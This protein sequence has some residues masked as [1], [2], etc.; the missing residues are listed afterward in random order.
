MGQYI[1]VFRYMRLILFYTINFMLLH[2]EA[3]VN[4]F[5][6]A[7][8]TKS[9]INIPY[10]F[11]LFTLS[12]SELVRTVR[13]Q[14]RHSQRPNIETIG[15]PGGMMMTFRQVQVTA[16]KRHTEMSV[17]KCIYDYLEYHRLLYT[18]S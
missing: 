14:L 7:I 6:I 3:C 9:H 1:I 5:H 15:Q 12:E 4:P 16:E 13:Q 8:R 11:I 18:C 17:S 10:A 2:Y